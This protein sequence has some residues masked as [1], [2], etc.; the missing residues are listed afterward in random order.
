MGEYKELVRRGWKALKVQ[1]HDD[2]DF[3]T[4]IEELVEENEQLRKKVNDAYWLATKKGK[5]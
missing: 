2:R 1:R 3:V 5:G 4:A